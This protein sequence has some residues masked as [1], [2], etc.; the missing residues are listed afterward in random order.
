MFREYLL[1]RLIKQ[2]TSLE[3]GKNSMEKVMVDIHYINA[4][5]QV[6][7]RYLY[8]ADDS[9][10]VILEMVNNMNAAAIEEMEDDKTRRLTEKARMVALHCIG[11]SPLYSTYKEY[12]KEVKTWERMHRAWVDWKSYGSWATNPMEC[13]EIEPTHFLYIIRAD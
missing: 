12:R 7:G 6:E 8:E 2:D 3:Q 1:K 10:I 4:S 9:D 5:E 11:K 13:P